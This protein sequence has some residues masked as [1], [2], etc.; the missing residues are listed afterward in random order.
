[1]ISQ[2]QL[3]LTQL[4]LCGRRHLTMA[5]PIQLEKSPNELPLLD[6]RA[7]DDWC[8]DIDRSDILAILSRVPDDARKNIAEIEKAIAEGNLAACKRAA[9]RLKGMAG[10][11]GA[12]RLAGT[13]R[14]IEV[15]S[16]SLDEAAGQLA[17]LQ[18]T[19]A[20]T[21]AALD[22]AAHSR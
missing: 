13:A 21:L 1:M 9:H 5:S 20:A 8:S 2:F 16:A 14:D 6:E 12:S 15:K 18:A 19:L 3:P 10:N 4:P 11:L 22:R 7:M 17:S